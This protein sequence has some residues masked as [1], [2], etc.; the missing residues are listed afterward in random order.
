MDKPTA[1]VSPVCGMENT[2]PNDNHFIFLNCSREWS[3]LV[4]KEELEETRA[5]KDTHG[6]VLNDG[7]TITLIKD[8]KSQ[9][10]NIVDRRWHQ[11][12]KHSLGRWRPWH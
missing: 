7:D 4:P 8:I 6:N 5:R 9:R 11:D 1:P 12:Q 3:A 10:L 2:Y